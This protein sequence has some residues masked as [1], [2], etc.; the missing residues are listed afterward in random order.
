M[1]TIDAVRQQ[2]RTPKTGVDRAPYATP[3]LRRFGSL[4]EHT[5]SAGFQNSA[6]GDG[7]TGFRK[8][9]R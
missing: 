9:T 8:K 2:P 6:A 3:S 4:S 7:G 1:K 5:K